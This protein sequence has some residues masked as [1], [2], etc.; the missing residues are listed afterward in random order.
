MASQERST[1]LPL[2][3]IV[4]DGRLVELV[5]LTLSDSILVGF[6]DIE[7]ERIGTVVMREDGPGFVAQP[8]HLDWLRYEDREARLLRAAV[9]F[10]SQ[11]T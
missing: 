9:H 7:P 5:W 8:G 2:G 6:P 11:R 4:I 10:R 1:L 3:S